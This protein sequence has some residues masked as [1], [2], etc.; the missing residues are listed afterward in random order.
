MGKQRVKKE[1]IE[2]SKKID[3]DRERKG[4]SEGEITRRKEVRK[5]PR[6]KDKKEKERMIKNKKSTSNI[7][8]GGNYPAPS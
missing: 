8:P 5:M 1:L 4:A 2:S 6:L 3:K 7:G